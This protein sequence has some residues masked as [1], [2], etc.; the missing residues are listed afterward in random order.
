MRP[1][2]NHLIITLVVSDE[3]HVIVVSNLTH[4]FITLLDQVS[5]LLRDNNIIEVE[6][7][8][9]QISHTVTEV[10]DSIKEFTSLSETYVLNHIGDDVAQ[11]LLR[12]NSIH[13][14]NLLRNDA[15]D[16][17]TTN[18]SLNHTALGL[19]VNDIVDNHLHL[20]V[21]VALA[22]VMGDDCLLGTVEGKTLTLGTR[23]DLGDVVKTKHHIL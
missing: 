22:L 6:R 1:G 15:I 4:L 9:S 19:A 3:S 16:D 8:T 2:I 17:D 5:L 7:Q 10:L 11:T 12:D 21:E 23:T 13:E 18:R 20:S 14:T